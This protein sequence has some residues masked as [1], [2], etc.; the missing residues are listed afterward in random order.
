MGTY[1]PSELEKFESASEL[2]DD[3]MKKVEGIEYPAYVHGSASKASM[4]YQII[5]LTVLAEGKSGGK[6]FLV[7]F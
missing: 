4:F 1:A 7:D 2:F 5:A 6:S 3:L